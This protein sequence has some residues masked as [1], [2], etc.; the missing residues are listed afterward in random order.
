M[1]SAQPQLSGAPTEFSVLAR[2]GQSVASVERAIRAAG[3]TVVTSNVAVGLITATA[4][5]NGF[6]ERVSADRSVFGAAKAKPIG[7]APKSNKAKVKPNVVEKESHGSASKPKA[8][9]AQSAGLDPLDSQLWGLKSVRSDLSRTVQPGDKRVKVG[10][11]DTGVDASHPD[12]AP[13][14]DRAL[15][16]NFTKDIVA[17]VKGEPVD[18]PCEYRGCVDPA[19]VD[20]NGHGTHVAGT[21]GA[22]ANGFGV[23]GV[24]PN[25]T[26]VNLRAGQDSGF[27][28][29]QP[30]VDAITYAGDAGVDVVNMSFYTDPWLY[31]CTSNPADSAAEQAE[32]RTVIEATTRA[33]NYAHRKGVT[34]VVSLG[35]QHTD[36]G[37]PQPD[38]SSPDYPSNSTHPRQ[39]DNASCLSLPV[40]G[41]H[42]I[43]VS[44]FGPS[45][46]KAD[47]SNYGLEQ[48]SVSAPGGYFRDG[49]GTPWFRA[50]E[51]QILSTYPRNVGVAEGK[52]DA[53]GNITPDGLDDGV[54]KATTADGRVGYYQWLQ[55]TSMASPHATGVAAL[56]VSQYGKGSRDFGMNPDAVQRVL[57]GTA[58]DIA[59]PVPRTVDYLD[60]GRDASYTATCVGDASFNGFYGHGA[61]DAWSAVTRGSQ[62]LRG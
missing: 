39:I 16:Q 18:G 40:E 13:N 31:N 30:T 26:L 57:E 50:I 10:I 59:C 17:D 32:Q 35:N 54:Q 3:G 27:F 44:S 23:S 33:L 51:N 4:P 47:Y 46:A 34:Q 24:A 20:D 28:F 58:S 2:E 15:S 42:T 12:I 41:P 14:F 38:A 19:D 6:A 53:A 1:A 55:G 45:Q 60:E 7:S 61:V 29:L 62:F 56:I 5:A 9:S 11:I 25:V 49:F 36:L 21:I 48:I 22:A 52:I 8:A 37:A 43:G